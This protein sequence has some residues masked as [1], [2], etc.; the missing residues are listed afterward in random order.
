LFPWPKTPVAVNCAVWPAESDCDVGEIE[1]ETA[2]GLVQPAMGNA[3]AMK[4]STRGDKTRSCIVDPPEPADRF[5]LERGASWQTL[6]GLYAFDYR[7]CKQR[8]AVT[9][10][11]YFGLGIKTVNK[12]VGIDFDG[13]FARHFGHV[14]GSEKRDF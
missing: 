10:R 14:C 4:R 6:A 12:P 5:D 9:R 2:N 13:S 1:T 7:A 3:K 8:T 11:C